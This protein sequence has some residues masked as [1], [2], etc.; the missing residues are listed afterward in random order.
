[1]SPR[2]RRAEAWGP[3][4]VTLVMAGCGTSYETTS[5][6]PSSTSEPT[7]PGEEGT[8]DGASGAERGGVDAGR[9]A[10]T[11]A[12][13]GRA[14][15]GKDASTAPTDFIGLNDIPVTPQLAGA[16]YFNGSADIVVV[17]GGHVVVSNG[18]HVQAMPFKSYA[19]VSRSVAGGPLS[20]HG[21][22]VQCETPLATSGQS[23][24]FGG[25]SEDSFG[26]KTSSVY[27]AQ[28]GVMG[29]TAIA[30][31]V[32]SPVLVVQPPISGLAVDPVTAGVFVLPAGVFKSFDP[33]LVGE[34]GPALLSPIRDVGGTFGG[35]GPFPSYSAG[36]NM[37]LLVSRGSD[38]VYCDLA[39]QAL[40]AIPKAGGAAKTLASSVDCRGLTTSAAGDLLVPNGGTSSCVTGL[41]YVSPTNV[42]SVI[43]SSLECI[44]GAALD[45]TYAYATLQNPSLSAHAPGGAAGTVIRMPIADP[46]AVQ[47]LASGQAKPGA[48]AIDGTSGSL[49]FGVSGAVRRLVLP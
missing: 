24:Y 46:S 2:H 16:F 27:R 25:Q 12:A 1:M 17:P 22:R 7:T 45:G 40:V 5:A 38:V 26:K 42:T 35:F 4:L 32:V 9:R 29:A 10:A 19:A 39:Q 34:L 11:D 47:V 28:P 49:F 15:A 41:L 20:L 48:L 13:V 37:R 43:A 8:G 30:D 3:L 23:F 18:S 21:E 6:P 36:V 14:D 44:G 33:V 31:S